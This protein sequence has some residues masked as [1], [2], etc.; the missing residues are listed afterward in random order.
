MGVLSV[1]LAMLIFGF[2]ITIHELGHFLVAK[3]CRVKINEFAIGMG[4]KLIGKKSKRSGTLYSLRILPI[5]GYVSMEGENEVS[6]AEGSFSKKPA[7][8]KLLISLAGPAM[9]ILLGFVLTF[10]LVIGMR[11]ADGIKLA[12]TRISGFSNNAISVESGLLADD[13]VTKVGNVSVH[14]GTELVYEISMQG[15]TAKEI[16]RQID[17]KN[18]LSKVVELDLTVIRGGDTVL[19]KNV[20][21]YADTSSG[22]VTM[23]EVDFG[24]YAETASFGN[25]MKHTFFRSLSSVKMIWDNIIG[26]FTGRFGIEAMSGPIGTTEAIATVAQEGWYTLLYFV[27]IITMNLG[28]FNLLPVL[29]L[30]GGHNLFHIYELIMRKPVPKKV[31]TALQ[32]FGVILMFGLILIVSIKDII[33]LFS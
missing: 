4:P 6:D 20:M 10:I 13:I 28:V 29:P 9:N 30:D 27:T 21:F 15:D 32:V 8:Q 11:D 33:G 5:G 14:T 12:S 3:A 31:E 24:V 23:G 25:I 16:Y 18:V 17:G 7:W 1:V 26:L 2:M 19:L 22:I